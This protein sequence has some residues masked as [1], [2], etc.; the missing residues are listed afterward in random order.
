VREEREDNF[1]KWEGFN[2]AGSVLKLDDAEGQRLTSPVAE[3]LA[4]GVL[5]A[6]SWKA[7]QDTV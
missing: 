7:I 1:K 4:N 2:G 6:G 3:R 5:G